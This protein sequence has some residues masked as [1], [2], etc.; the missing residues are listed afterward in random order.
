MATEK[1]ELIGLCSEMDLVPGSASLHHRREWRGGVFS[2]VVLGSLPSPVPLSQASGADRLC[3]LVRVRLLPH[4]SLR[5]CPGKAVCPGQVPGL[6]CWAGTELAPR[7]ASVGPQ[8][9]GQ[10]ALASRPLSRSRPS[11]P[12]RPPPQVSLTTQLPASPG[13]RSSPS[14]ATTQAAPREVP[15]AIRPLPVSSKPL[16]L[17]EEVLP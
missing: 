14:S 15:P 16:C 6:A 2:A 1:G 4:C 10:S 8:G 17:R 5:T 3:R 9:P 12:P 11:R 7:P 13:P